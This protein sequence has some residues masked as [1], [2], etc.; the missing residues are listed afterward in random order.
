MKGLNMPYEELA[1]ELVSFYARERLPRGVID[2][3]EMHQMVDNVTDSL[4]FALT[5]AVMGEDG[6]D[7]VADWVTVLLPIRPRWIPK[8]A[9]RRIPTRRARWELRV[10][11]MW[12]YPHSN[13]KVPDLG[14]PV[15][16][17][18]NHGLTHGDGQWR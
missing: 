10:Q 7:E 14:Q 5:T 13:I 11:P 9:W 6:G 18:V 1:M 4:I 2:R 17:A 8:W 3:V 12:T 16:I 15:R